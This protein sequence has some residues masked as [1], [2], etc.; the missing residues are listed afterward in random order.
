MNHVSQSHDEK[1]G[2]V[3]RDVYT[4]KSELTQV[5]QV[6]LHQSDGRGHDVDQS[7]HVVLMRVQSDAHQ[8]TQQTQK[9]GKC[10]DFEGLRER[11]RVSES[12][13]LISRPRR[14]LAWRKQ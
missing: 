12:L 3:H 10:H 14:F 4:A 13:F 5:T 1:D 2:R 8:A 9:R 7:Q 11:A 6:I